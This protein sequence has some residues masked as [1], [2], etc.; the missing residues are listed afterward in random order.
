MVPE[1]PLKTIVFSFALVLAGPTLA[2][3]VAVWAHLGPVF[4]WTWKI[5]QWPIVFALASTGMALIYYFAPDVKQDWIWL[6]PGSVFATFLW[7][8]ATL[9]FKLLHDFPSLRI[10]TELD[11]KCSPLIATFRLIL[12]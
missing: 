5:L 8:L 1:E 9:G 7:L 12:G 10:A 4:E 11:E 6:T 3:K 2:E